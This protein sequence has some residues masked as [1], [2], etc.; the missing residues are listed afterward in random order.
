MIE[1]D[2]IKYRD[3]QTKA[4][5]QIRQTDNEGYREVSGHVVTDDGIVYVESYWYWSA[6]N[7]DSHGNTTIRF[8]WD[9]RLRVMEEPFFRWPLSLIHAAKRFVNDVIAGRV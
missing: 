6:E 4:H 8:V 5:N 7:H 1:I 2:G 9:G 3:L